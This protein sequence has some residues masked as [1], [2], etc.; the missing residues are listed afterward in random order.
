MKRISQLLL[1]LA[2]MFA[3]ASAANA[4]KYQDTIARQGRPDVCRCACGPEIHVYA[5]RNEIK[6]NRIKINQGE[7]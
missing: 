5:A 2:T 4:G 6:K 1:F 3:A 7:E